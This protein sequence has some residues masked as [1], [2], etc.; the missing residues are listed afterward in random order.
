MSSAPGSEPVPQR[1]AR[2]R[3]QLKLLSEYLDPAALEAQATE[4][5]RRMG[6]PGF[7]DDQETAAKVGAEH[8]RIKRRLDTFNGLQTDVADLEGLLELSEEDPSIAAELEEQ[9]A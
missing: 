1:I 7:W 8:A 9:L 4:L 5:E 6:E 3:E 2:V